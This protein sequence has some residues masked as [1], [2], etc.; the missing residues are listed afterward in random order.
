MCFASMCQVSAGGSLTNSLMALA[1]LG[2]AEHAVHGRGQLRVAM[3]GII[4]SDVLSS[5]YNV[6]M[7]QAG[8]EVLARPAPQ[9]C[10][11]EIVHPL[12]TYSIT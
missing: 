2:A 7:K 10:T 5:F 9:S 11:G 12:Q 4:G 3:D 1:R 6:Q 8:V